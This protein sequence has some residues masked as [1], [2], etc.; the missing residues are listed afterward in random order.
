MEDLLGVIML[1]PWSHLLR[2]TVFGNEAE[3]E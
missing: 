1:H 3:G 2:D